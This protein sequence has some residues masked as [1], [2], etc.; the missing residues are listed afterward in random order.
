MDT[1]YT[2]LSTGKSSSVLWP[3]AEAVS[4]CL[5]D[6]D[7]L[8]LAFNFRSSHLTGMWLINN[9]RLL[10]EKKN[11]STY[12]RKLPC[13]CKSLSFSFGIK[14]CAKMSIISN[15]YQV[16]TKYLQRR[17]LHK[18]H[19]CVCGHGV[20]PSTRFASAY[21][22]VCMSIWRPEVNLLRSHTPCWL[23]HSFS[24][25]LLWVPGVHLSLLLKDWIT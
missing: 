13:L 6:T 22:N 14:L 4:R 18:L 2:G 24:L 11:K 20:P 9:I 8:W 21:A 23:R 25:S 15:K 1:N 10:G 12:T 19:V 17:P 16:H 3:L 5:V 7:C